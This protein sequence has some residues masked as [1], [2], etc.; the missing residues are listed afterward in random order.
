MTKTITLNEP[1]KVSGGTIWE[2]WKDSIELSKCGYM[3]ELSLGDLIAHWVV[4]SDKVDK[5]WERNN[6][7]CVTKPLGNNEYKIGNY[8]ISREKALYTL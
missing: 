5:A 7:T 3:E 4:N 8:V 6:I 1:D 2:T